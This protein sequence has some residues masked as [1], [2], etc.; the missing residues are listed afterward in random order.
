[1]DFLQE[2]NNS[3][4]TSELW[5]SRLGTAKTEAISFIATRSYWR[6][7]WIIQETQL[8]SQLSLYCGTRSIPIK[9]LSS[10]RYR[11]NGYK[12]AEISSRLGTANTPADFLLQQREKCLEGLPQCNLGPWLTWAV[13]QESLYTEPRD[14]IYALLGVTAD[15]QSGIIEPDYTKPFEEVFSDII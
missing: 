2:W 5:L 14:I 12:E 13:A 15:C 7:M 1:M 3:G 10:Y 8:A 4:R 9:A 11:V 6:R